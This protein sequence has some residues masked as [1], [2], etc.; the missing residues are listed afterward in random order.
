MLRWPR[1]TRLTAPLAALVL[2]ACTEPPDQVVMPW[3]TEGSG[4]TSM[5]DPTGGPTT[6]TAG[7]TTMVGT[8]GG[9]GME[10]V[11]ETQNVDTTMGASASATTMGDTT[12]GDTTMGVDPTTGPEPECMGPEECDPNEDCVGGQCVSE[13]AAWG[14]NDYSYCMTELGTYDSAT[15]CGEPYSCVV[16]DNPTSTVVCG[17]TCGSACDCPA[18]PATGTAPVTCGNI[19]NVSDTRCYLSC[20][21][22]EM[23][24]DGMMCQDDFYCTH[25]TQ[26]L[27]MYG[28]CGATTAGC[29]NGG[30]CATASGMN[31][32]A[33]CIRPCANVGTCDPAPPGAAQGA[34]C[35]SVYPG[36]GLECHL[37]CND[38]PDC[39]PGMGC[40]DIGATY[41][42]FCMWLQ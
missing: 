35:G 24:P 9:S 3:D 5:P 6:M 18:P 19:P 8:Q 40:I 41:G 37:D 36:G 38:H 20:E 29:A 16:D 34:G 25:P 42:S 28:D 23:C 39:P 4:S 26:P 15:I 1:R 27:Q 2:S 10:T 11:G 12:M 31:N 33:V 32:W 30:V 13:C 7:A 17:R 14:P 21:N 22:G